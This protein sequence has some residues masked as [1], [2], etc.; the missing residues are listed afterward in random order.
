MKQC[1]FC[2]R[3]ENEMVA[4]NSLAVAFYD[5]YPVNQG[6]VLIVPKRHVPTLFDATQEELVAIS[7]LL[8]R[9]KEI[10]DEKYHPDGYNVGVNVEAAGGQTIFH[11]HC[12]VIPRYTGDVANPRGGIRKIKR[13]LVPYAL[14]GEGSED[15]N[16]NDCSE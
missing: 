10:L 6:H 7:E 16:P 3:Q 11:L 1:I 5:K 13:P 4:E 8:F 15:G 2:Q 12:H 9:V 14:E